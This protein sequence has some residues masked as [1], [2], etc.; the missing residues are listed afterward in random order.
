MCFLYQ[1]SRLKIFGKCYF[2]PEIREGGGVVGGSLTTDI[3]VDG[4]VWLYRRMK[5][6]EEGFE[7]RT[8]GL[9]IK[10]INKFS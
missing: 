8:F 7:P 4:C 6:A 3:C 1:F 5:V 2:C 10:I 9:E